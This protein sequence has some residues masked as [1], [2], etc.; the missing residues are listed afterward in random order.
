L[1]LLPPGFFGLTEGQ[2]AQMAMMLSVAILGPESWQENVPLLP[3]EIQ[4][5]YFAL[6]A[7]GLIT[8]MLAFQATVSKIPS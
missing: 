4:W 2:V 6:I 7:M 1:Y 5:R 8:F 3:F